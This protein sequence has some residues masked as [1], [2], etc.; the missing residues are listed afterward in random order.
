MKLNN[1]AVERALSELARSLPKASTPPAMCTAF[2]NAVRRAVPHERLLVFRVRPGDPPPSLSPIAWPGANGE[3]D[4]AAV[5]VA[6]AAVSSG[7]P[8]VRTERASKR[9][10]CRMAVPMITNGA[11]VGVIVAE[12][13][14]RAYTP[15]HRRAALDT[16]SVLAGALAHADGAAMLRRRE[17]EAAVLSEVNRVISSAIDL[18]DVYEHFAEEMQKLIQSDRIALLAIDRA[19]QTFTV[20]YVSGIH[21]PGMEPGETFQLA[22]SLTAAVSEK[23]AGVLV[24]GDSPEGL[25]ARYPRLSAIAAAGIRSVMAVPLLSR[26]EVIGA[27]HISS[28]RPYAYDSPDLEVAE[29]VGSLIASTVANAELYRQALNLAEEREL[30]ARLDAENRELLRIDQVK[31][32]FFSLVSHELK[33]PLTTMVAFADVLAANRDGNLTPRQLQ[34][35]QV[36]Q[37]NGRRLNLLV[38]DLFDLARIETG[39]FKLTRREF[40]ARKLLQDQVASFAPIIE[41]KQQEIQVDIPERDIW[42]EAD[43]DRLVQIVSNLLSNAAKYS[44]NGTKIQMSAAVDGDRLSVTV[45]DQGIGIAKKHHRDIFTAFFRADN[46]ETR[47]APGTGLGLFITKTLIEMHGGQIEVDSDTG[48]GTTMSFYIRGVLPGPSAGTRGAPAPVPTR[49]RLEAIDAAPS[50]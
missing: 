5:R 17:N 24:T 25:A 40:E 12:A 31:R 15:A 47:S 33:T 45:R 23:R 13:R 34:Q 1:P 28:A 50:T 2:A 21:V 4:P 49:S 3:V 22:G 39:G 43:P 26:N 41:R 7:R 9:P 37:R 46:E 20:T 32:R 16:G 27:L 48:R 36:M 14:G 19:A 10:F 38:E 30:R 11:V 35:L 18:D 8:V 44:Q 42:I 6:E 29:R